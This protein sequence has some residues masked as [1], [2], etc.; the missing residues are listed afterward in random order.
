MSLLLEANQAQGGDRRRP[1]AEEQA[2]AM[3][4][5]AGRIDGRT[6]P[7][8]PTRSTA[9][10]MLELILENVTTGLGSRSDGSRSPPLHLRE[11]IWAGAKFT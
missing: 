4:S 6:L 2:L 11:L 1:R 9:R 8:W 10:S 3:T 7:G 5:R